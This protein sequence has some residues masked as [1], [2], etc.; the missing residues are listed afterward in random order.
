MISSTLYLFSG[1]I[2]HNIF[3]EVVEETQSTVEARLQ[4]DLPNLTTY[5]PGGKYLNLTYAHPA[6]VKL[7]RDGRISDDLL[8]SGV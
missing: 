4:A 8:G 2:L 1:K 5:C 7:P 3:L 6:I